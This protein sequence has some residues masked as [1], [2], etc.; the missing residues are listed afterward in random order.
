MALP[1]AKTSGMAGKGVQ[2]IS[3]IHLTAT[4]DIPGGGCR[5]CIVNLS[6]AQVGPKEQNT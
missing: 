5:F 1:Q 6:S 3:I 4:N 2:Q